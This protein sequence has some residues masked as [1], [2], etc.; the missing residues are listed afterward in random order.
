MI[1]VHTDGGARGNPGPAAIG[2]VINHPTEGKTTFGTY[3]GYT[4]NNIAE[5]T[6]VIEALRHLISHYKSD[7]V[8]FFLDSELVQKQLSGAYRIKDP[9]LKLLARRVFALLDQ[10]TGSYSF[11]HI[12]R[13]K[14]TEADEIVNTV[15]DR[16]IA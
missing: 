2:V 13:E 6:A 3:L 8:I 14:N 5:Y 11:V 1:T 4:T 9:K 7:D 15:L 16:E 10:W 12:P